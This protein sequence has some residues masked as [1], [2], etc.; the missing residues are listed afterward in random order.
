V[1][2][3]SSGAWLSLLVLALAASLLAAAAQIAR[4]GRA[5]Y[6]VLLGCSV[7]VLLGLYSRY[8]VVL[9]ALFRLGSLENFTVF[10][11]VPD[12]CSTVRSALPY[13]SRN[14]IGRVGRWINDSVFQEVDLEWSIPL[15]DS[16]EWAPKLTQR[17]LVSVPFV[18][19]SGIKYITR[20]QR[21]RVELTLLSQL[22]TTPGFTTDL[23]EN[24]ALLQTNEHAFTRTNTSHTQGV[25]DPRF[26]TVWATR[27]IAECLV[28]KY[29]MDAIEMRPC[30][31]Q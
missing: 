13:E 19:P 8:S 21:L 14:G 6:G 2:L 23:K 17:E 7:G 31:S 27:T 5:H 26:N 4:R 10:R 22:L 30:L 28:I 11:A 9:R 12:P 15:W 24:L 18:S 3:R 25:R 20:F 16:P 1:H 29:T